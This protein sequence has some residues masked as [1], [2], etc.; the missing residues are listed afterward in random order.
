[1]VTGTFDPVA[2]DELDRSLTRLPVRQ[3]EIL[4][5]SWVDALRSEPSVDLQE[6][7][8]NGVQTDV[9]IR[10]GTFGQ[11]LILLDGIRIDDVQS[12]HHDMDL[13][14]P[15]E[16]IDH[17]EV[18]RG[19]GST[20]YGSDAVGGVINVIT[21]AAR[22]LRAHPSHSRRQ[23]RRQPAKR[24]AAFVE[25]KVSEQLAFSR[26]FSTRVSVRPR[27]PQP[28]VRLRHPP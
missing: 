19:S 9:S 21:R 4:L 25:P 18:L 5:N 11:T 3:N 13:P 16:A 20:L 26:D 23:L 12:G 8:P 2:L 14:V 22:S 1:M 10:G 15:L 6:R 24:L 27:L 28:V 17:I 7:A